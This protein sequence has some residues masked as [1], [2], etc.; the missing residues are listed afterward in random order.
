MGQLLRGVGLTR[1][2]GKGPQAVRAL[3][4]LDFEIREGERLA[5]CGPSGAGK[6]TLLEILGL[7]DEGYEGQ[8]WFRGGDARLLARRARVWRRLA[9][10]G[11]VYQR[12]HLLD[13]LDARDNVALPCWRLHGDR[14]R[15]RRR[16]EELLEL[17]GLTE[18]SASH[19]SQL[20]SGEQQR[21]AVARALVNDPPLLLADEPTGNLDAISAEAVLAALD[22]AH[23]EGR[24][25]LM[26]THDLELARRAPRRLCLRYGAL[27]DDDQDDHARAEG[28]LRRV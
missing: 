18:R 17:L 16:A 20:S 21:V 27:V 24:T 23:A 9:D 26:V 14:R 1:V 28:D 15:A 2:Y 12:F 7:L 13:A 5:I 25:L 22:A 6:T 3:D 19:P 10:I 11:V 4:D 8:L